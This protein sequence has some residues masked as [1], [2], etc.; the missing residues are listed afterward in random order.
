MSL[1]AAI[2]WSSKILNRINVQYCR[3][4]NM[5]GHY[6]ATTLSPLAKLGG[7]HSHALRF[8]GASRSTLG[9]DHNT[10]Y[11]RT[12]GNG[13]PIFPKLGQCLGERF[14]VH[15]H[16]EPSCSH[17]VKLPEEAIC[18]PTVTTDSDIQTPLGIQL[19]KLK[20]HKTMRYAPQRKRDCRLIMKSNEVCII[21]A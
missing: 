16:Q 11:P 3:Q 1:L 2:L 4:I 12:G 14:D 7:V 18:L 15:P 8:L 10:P 19:S 5:P 13:F 6:Q 17:V 21:S 20:P 9:H